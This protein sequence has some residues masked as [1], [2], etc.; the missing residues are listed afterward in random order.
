MPFHPA[1]VVR[2]YTAARVIVND[3]GTLPDRIDAA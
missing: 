2:L 1:A 3:P